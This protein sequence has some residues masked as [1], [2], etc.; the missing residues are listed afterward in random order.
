MSNQRDELRV[1]HMSDKPRYR[2]SATNDGLQNIMTGLGTSKSHNANN[3]WVMTHTDYRQLEAAYQDNW[4]AQAIVDFRAEDMTRQWRRIK[5]DG[6]E[7]IA[8]L[9]DAMCLYLEVEKTIKWAR[10]YGGAGIVMLTNQ[11]LEKPLNLNKIKKGSLEGFHVLDRWDLQG[12]KLQFNR[13]GVQ[14]GKPEF[15]TLGNGASQRVHHSHVV[16]FEGVELPRR[17]QYFNN[18][19]GDSVLRRCIADVGEMVAAKTGIA[20]L[21]QEANVD[22]ITRQGLTDEIASD[23]DETIISR[24]ALFARMKSIVNMALLD[25]EETYDRHTLNLSGV[26]PIIQDMMTWVSGAAQTPVTRLFGKSASGLSATGEGDMRNYH[27]SISASQSSQLTRPLRQIDEV[28]VRSALGSW[29]KSFDYVWNP[30]AAPDSVEVAQ[31]EQLQAQKSQIYLDMGV[32]KKSQIM[33]NLQSNEEY[34]Y[35]DD[36]LNEL[37]E[38]E[39][40]NLFEGLPS[41]PSDAVGGDDELDPRV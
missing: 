31:A 2:V 15:Y 3:Q 34:Q 41:E 37:E 6:A 7:D 16:R 13:L 17:L 1:Q 29:P 26:S 4:I 23:Q 39:D 19:W 5:S 9:E 11:S 38:M 27:E 28:L 21:L 10:L 25:G 33:R 22:V 8:A 35:D 18:S 12:S 40:G 20:D 14:F 30:L 24:Y 36:E 32:V